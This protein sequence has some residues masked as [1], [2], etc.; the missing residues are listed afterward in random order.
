MLTSGVGREEA[1]GR[2]TVTE[3]AGSLKASVCQPQE[4]AGWS[5][6][7]T[8]SGGALTACSGSRQGLCPAR[9]GGKGAVGV[10]SSWTFGGGTGDGQRAILPD[11]AVWF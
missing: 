3:Q 1:E 2:Q 7:A 4:E 10:R 6:D 9:L 5:D 11:A 8:H